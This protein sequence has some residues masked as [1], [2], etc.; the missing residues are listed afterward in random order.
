MPEDALAR[1]LDVTVAST[2]LLAEYK[3]FFM[4]VLS[5]AAMAGYVVWALTPQPVLSALGITY[6]PDRYW[7]R[8]VPAYLLMLMLYVYVYVAMYNTE[9]KTPPL[10]DERFFSDSHAVYPE[11]PE[12]YVHSAPSAVWDLPVILVNDVLYGDDSRDDSRGDSRDD[13]PDDST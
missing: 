8:A 6:Y 12:A 5:T 1:E 7:A 4:Y 2:L 13:S 10:G 3:G 11:H 9:V